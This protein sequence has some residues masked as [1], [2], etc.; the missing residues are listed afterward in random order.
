MISVLVFLFGLAFGSFAGVMAT[1]MVA[2][3]SVV[4]P[5]S[6][7]ESCG[8]PLKLWHNIPLLSYILLKGKCAFCGTKISLFYPIMEL[9]GGI[10]F[11]SVYLRTGIG[12][13]FIFVSF[14]FLFLLVMSA[15]DLRTKTAPDSLNLLAFCMAA[16][17][18]LFGSNSFFETPITPFLLLGRVQDAFIMSGFL[19][20][21]KFTVE[22]FM[23][24]EALGEADILI[25][26]TIGVLLGLKFAMMALFFAA[27]FALIFLL[28]L[29]RNKDDEQVPFVPFLFSGAFVVYLLG[30]SF[31]LY[32]KVLYAF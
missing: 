14:T 13:H 21:L 23:K 15:I 12:F 4:S 32:M 18:A 9:L 25:V 20:F 22:Y 2:D 8:N 27:L 10:I 11:V 7:C 5:S 28:L 31:D 24:K 29:R 30:H 16:S 19:L 26:G 17:S 3:E 6:H 1:R